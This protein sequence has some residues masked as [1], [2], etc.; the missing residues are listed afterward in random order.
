M[1]LGRFSAFE[2]F[3]D[4]SRFSVFSMQVD[5]YRPTVFVNDPPHW[6]PLG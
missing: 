1:V 4:V 2:V 6:L 5:G 3:L